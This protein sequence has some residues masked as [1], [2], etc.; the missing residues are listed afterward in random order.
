MQIGSSDN[1]LEELEKGNEE[2]GG[3]VKIKKAMVTNSFTE[4][5]K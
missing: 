2:Y 3:G 4:S 1:V 5:V